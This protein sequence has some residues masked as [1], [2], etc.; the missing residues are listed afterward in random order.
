[1]LLYFSAQ[2]SGRRKNRAFQR[3][4]G[5]TETLSTRELKASVVRYVASEGTVIRYPFR[6]KKKTTTRT[7]EKV[8][9][10]PSMANKS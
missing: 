3:K 4:K 8:A 1:M 10:I 6:K 9:E 5:K 7:K 2:L